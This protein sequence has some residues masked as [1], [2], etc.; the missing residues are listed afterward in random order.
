MNIIHISST[1]L[2]NNVSEV[3]NNVYYKKIVT[4]IERHGKPIVKIVPTEESPLKDQKKMDV[5]EKLRKT[6]GSIPD[7]PDVTK[8]R[9]SRKKWPTL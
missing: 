7:F 2:K 3:I 1:E 4:I 6:F 5:A 8:F 9:L